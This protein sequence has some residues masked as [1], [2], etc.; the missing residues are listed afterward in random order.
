[1]GSD[2]LR[3]IARH[4]LLGVVIS[5]SVAGAE[6]AAAPDAPGAPQ[7]P[8]EARSPDAGPSVPPPTEPTPAAPPEA[9]AAEPAAPEAEP[10]A[11]AGEMRVAD[12]RRR[13][14]AA[15]RKARFRRT[16]LAERQ[17]VDAL[18]PLLLDR[19]RRGDDRVAD[20]MPTARAG[21]MVVE[22]WAV[23]GQVYLALLEPTDDT[24]GAGAYVFRVGERAGPFVLQAPHA[25]F[26]LSTGR[27]AVGMFFGARKGPRAAAL[28]VNTLQRYERGDASPN[29]RADVCHR[30]EHLFSLATDRVIEHLPGATVI[31]LHGFDGE[32][33]PEGVDMIL[34]AGVRET[35]SVGMTAT[36][37]R[38]RARFGKGVRLFPTQ[39]TVLGGTTNVQ[40]RIAGVRQAG[41][42]HVEMAR[43][44]REKLARTPGLRHA[45]ARALMGAG[46]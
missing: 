6:P 23:H 31:Q 19:A 33:A 4:A 46:R 34:S 27:I 3:A 10:A 35:P 25:Y 8:P 12:V 32:S 39:I 14:F 41:F 2:D 9:P 37:E 13:L 36:A 21:R 44:L 43:P 45:L 5:T 40:G 28:F 1:M 17:A 15:G 29:H 24:R 16:T 42:V 22:R 20:L 38:V 18:V 7:A 30:P 26:D 11:P